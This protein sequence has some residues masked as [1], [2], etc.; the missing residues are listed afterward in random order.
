MDR[1]RAE[2][3]DAATTRDSRASHLSRREFTTRIGGGSVAAAAG[4]VWATPKIST[5]RFAAKAAVGSPPPG[6]GTTT[7]STTIAGESTGSLSISGHSPC[8]G[9]KLHATVSGFAPKTAVEFQIDSPEHSLGVATADAQG[10]VSVTILIPKNA[11]TGRHNLVA[12]GVQPGGRTLKL[13]TRIEIKTEDE[14]KTGVEGST[15]STTVGQTGSTDTTAATSSTTTPTP[16]TAPPDNLA[17]TPPGKVSRGEGSLAFTG[18]DA[19]NLAL[20]G[21]GAA[22]GGRALLAI[23]GRNR[24]EDDEDDDD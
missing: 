3:S 9:D 15:T 22:V 23:A 7:T 6:G 21:A 12:V 5:I 17:E 14:C 8:G 24:D 18:T 13:S 16:T 4:M 10:K 11:P 2:P 20:L 19:V 1:Q